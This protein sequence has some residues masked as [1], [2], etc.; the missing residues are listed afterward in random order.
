MYAFRFG[1]R[2]VWRE[3]IVILSLTCDSVVVVGV[4]ILESYHLDFVKSIRGND[5]IKFTFR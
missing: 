5:E 2:L 1:V 3:S 4:V